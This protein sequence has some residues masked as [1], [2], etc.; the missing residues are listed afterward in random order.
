[1][2]NR[3]AADADDRVEFGEGFLRALGEGEIVAGGK[4]MRRIEADLQAFWSGN[5]PDDLRDLL[6]A[7]TDARSLAGGGFERDPD[8]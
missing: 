7:G 2:Q 5:A 4:S 3:E 1:M 8:V 6:E